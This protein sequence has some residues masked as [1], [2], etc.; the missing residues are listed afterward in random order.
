MNSCFVSIKAQASCSVSP[1]KK[2]KKFAL[3]SKINNASHILPILNDA[4][5]FM[6]NCKTHRKTKNNAFQVFNSYQKSKKQKEEGGTHNLELIEVA[7]V[8]QG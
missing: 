7:E 8:K 6:N 1:Q 3:V 4:F 2:K 5:L